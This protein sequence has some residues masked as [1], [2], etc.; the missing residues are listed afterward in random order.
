MK[1]D[2]SPQPEEGEEEWDFGTGVGEGKGEEDKTDDYKFEEQLLGEKGGEEDAEEQGEDQEEEGQEGDD[3]EERNEDGGKEMENDFDG[4]N[5]DEDDDKE[6][7]EKGDEDNEMDD[8]NQDQIDQDLWGDQNE[9]REEGESS[10]EQD[11]QDRRDVDDKEYEGKEPNRNEETEQAP[12][13]GNDKEQRAATDD[14]QAQEQ[15]EE[16][17]KEPE[18]PEK[19]EDDEYAEVESVSEMSDRDSNKKMDFDEEENNPDNN[20]QVNPEDDEAQ[21]D[22]LAEDMPS[23]GDEI[24]EKLDE[25]PVDQEHGDSEVL[26]DPLN[27]PEREMPPEMDKDDQ[28]GGQEDDTHDQAVK[29]SGLNPEATK[30]E[31][32][33]KDKE[34]RE[35]IKNKEKRNKGQQAGKKDKPNAMDE[36]SL[37]DKL[38]KADEQS[39]DGDSQDQEKKDSMQKLDKDKKQNAVEDNP[40]KPNLKFDQNKLQELVKELM[41][42]NNLDEDQSQDG[43]DDG[44]E[45]EGLVHGGDEQVRIKKNAGADQ[46]PKEEKDQKRARDQNSSELPPGFDATKQEDQDEQQK[47]ET[48]EDGQEGGKELMDEEDPDQKNENGKREDDMAQDGDQ[49]DPEK[50]IKRHGSD[51]MSEE[52]LAQLNT[53]SDIQA[54]LQLL[55]QDYEHPTNSNHSWHSIEPQLRVRAFNLS[56]ELRCIFK[57]TKVAAMK[58]DY[59][60]GKRLNMRKVVS[61]VASNYR[62]DKIWLRRA[63]PSQRDYEIMLAIDDTLSMSEKNVGYLALEGMIT[64][65]LALS[66]M[67]VGKLG[68][69]GIRNG[70]HEVL[71][72]NS[73]FIPSSEGQKILD[74]FTFS[75]NDALSA[76]LGLPNFLTQVGDKFS[77]GPHTRM[78]FIL[79]DGKCNKDL[80]RPAVR[81]LEEAHQVMVIY[82]ILDRKED[83]GSILNLRSTEFVSEDGGPRKVKIKQYLDDFP[84]TNYVIV[85]DVNELAGVMVSILRDYFASMD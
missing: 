8:V 25:E 68:I 11:P 63:D 61:Y 34:Q 30:E 40:S 35:E 37:E 17:Q 29:D 51:D 67:E 56:E 28:Q 72:F 16:E 52:E 5:H 39:I 79:S 62:K 74:E 19:K 15:K 20:S 1:K 84:F 64:L 46:I 6:D 75:F 33:Q 45:I 59:R 69:A 7:E 55:N 50:R 26:D 66:K 3:P 83:K 49:P 4:D 41:A 36:E 12:K 27:K 23:I 80:V 24:E 73:P 53:F 71:G 32:G 65:A 77:P 82:I 48:E 38:S 47:P 81:H 2:D 13:E 76:D 44:D 18:E 42:Q 70:L 14:Y 21:E 9:E 78:L 31:Q 85:Q 10:D 58:G 54:F 57:P 43:Q 60:T 22:P